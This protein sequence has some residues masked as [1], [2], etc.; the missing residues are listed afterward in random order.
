MALTIFPSLSGVYHL[1]ASQRWSARTAQLRA[2]AV[3][4]PQESAGLGLSCWR[5][6][7]I[8]NPEHRKQPCS[9]RWIISIIAEHA[10]ARLRVTLSHSHEHTAT[11]VRSGKTLPPRTSISPL[12]TCPLPR[13]GPRPGSPRLPPAAR[14]PVPKIS[15]ITLCGPRRAHSFIATGSR[16]WRA[17]SD[18]N[19][20]KNKRAAARGP[21]R[22]QRGARRSAA[23]PV[24]GPFRHRSVSS[25]SRARAAGAGTGSVERESSCRRCNPCRKRGGEDGGRGQQ[26]RPDRFAYSARRVSGRRRACAAAFRA[27]I[28]MQCTT[29]RVQ[30]PMP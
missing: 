28:F 8:W 16:I 25:Y 29:L 5:A 2:G 15:S 23:E 11:D 20:R 10:V 14:N 17:V 7:G 24:S 27:C 12:P 3:L 18:E 1:H 4:E 6:T 13:T 22:V 26:H 19:K 30:S 9:I 21:A